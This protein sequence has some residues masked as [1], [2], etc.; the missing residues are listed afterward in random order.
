VPI[1]KQHGVPV[2][3]EF[4]IPKLND[5]V[6]FTHYIFHVANSDHNVELGNF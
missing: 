1:V 3:A 6:I 2:A 4:T 5:G